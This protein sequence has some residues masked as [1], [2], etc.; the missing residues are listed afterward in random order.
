MPFF[1]WSAVFRDV[2][3]TGAKHNGIR[4]ADDVDRLLAGPRRLLEEDAANRGQRLGMIFAT[5]VNIR[6]AAD[7]RHVIEFGAERRVIHRDR[8]HIARRA[9]Q[10]L[11][12]A[13]RPEQIAAVDL[14]ERG[15][16]QVAQAMAGDACRRR[17]PLQLLLKA[18][19]AASQRPRNALWLRRWLARLR[20]AMA[21]LEAE[22][23]DI[24]PERAIA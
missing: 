8:K 19:L 4:P 10:S 9:Q 3:I 24:A 11:R 5:R 1:T 7:L 15:D 2:E 22:G 16:N 13:D 18:V 21:G 6:L 17:H 12:V 20:L 23:E 14:L